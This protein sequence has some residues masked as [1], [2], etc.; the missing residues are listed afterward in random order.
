[1]TAVSSGHEKTRPIGLSW[2]GCPYQ[3]TRTKTNAR[4]CWLD[5]LPLSCQSGA[6]SHTLIPIQMSVAYKAC[7][8]MF[9]GVHNSQIE[10][11]VIGPQWNVK[12]TNRPSAL[13]V[14]HSGQTIW[15]RSPKSTVYFDLYSRAVPI[16]L[17]N[18]ESRWATSDVKVE[19]ECF[20]HWKCYTGFLFHSIFFLRLIWFSSET[21][22]THDLYKIY[23]I[24]ILPRYL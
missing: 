16:C 22:V 14:E 4:H 11:S 6:G 8:C 20:T 7:G 12:S 10:K 15:V 3:I 2:L 21:S 23:Q 1:M 18:H 13:T 19:N 24:F 9:T 17:T 5:W